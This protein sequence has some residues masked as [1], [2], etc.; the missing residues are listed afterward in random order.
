MFYS[1]KRFIGTDFFVIRQNKL[2]AKH[3]WGNIQKLIHNVVYIPITCY[4]HSGHQVNVKYVVNIESP[5][6]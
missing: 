1:N 2:L 5:I 6:N 3:Y 4:K